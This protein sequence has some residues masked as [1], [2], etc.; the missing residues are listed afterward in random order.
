[1]NQEFEDIIKS[2][3]TKEGVKISGNGII[4]TELNKLNEK[5][6]KLDKK[7]YFM[8]K[9]QQEMFEHMKQKD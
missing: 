5:M 8:E 7:L 1:M 4:I 2:I 3:I 6:D 9:R